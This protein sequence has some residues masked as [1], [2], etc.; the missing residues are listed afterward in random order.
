MSKEK[1]VTAEQVKAMLDKLTTS[2]L[3]DVSIFMQ[4]M[5]AAADQNAQGEA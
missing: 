4:G 2:Q 1:K 5:E 3:R